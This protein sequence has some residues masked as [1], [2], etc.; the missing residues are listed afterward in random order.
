MAKQ[1]REKIITTAFALFLSKGYKN[2][3]LSDIITATASSKGAIYHYFKNKRAIYLEALEMFFFNLYEDIL[4]DDAELSLSERLKTRYLFLLDLIDFVEN[5][6]EGIHFPIRRYFLFQLESEED[7]IIRVKILDTL[8]KYRLEIT[9]IIVS[10]FEKKEITITL[11]A[12]VIAQQ[13]IG[14]IEGI[15]IHHS[16][17]EKNSKT[18]LLQKY[19]EVIQPYINLITHN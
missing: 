4:I 18:F 14:M 17:L 19:N 1:G 7:E 11:S 16:T 13:L 5:T 12:P 15:M 2:T 6:G 8:Q 10:S 3:S 9:Q